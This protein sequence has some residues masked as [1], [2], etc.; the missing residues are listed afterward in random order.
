V[1]GINLFG[2]ISI[3][4]LLYCAPLAVIFESAQWPAALQVRAAQ[5]VPAPRRAA[6]VRA[7]VQGEEGQ[8]PVG[9]GPACCCL[10]GQR[11]GPLLAHLVPPA[12]KVAGGPAAPQEECPQPGRD[13]PTGSTS[14]T[15]QASPLTLTESPPATTLLL[16]APDLLQ[17][18]TDS[19]GA[20]GFYQLLAVGGLFYHLYN[21]V[22]WAGAGGGGLHW[23]Y[24]LRWPAPTRPSP[25]PSYRRPPT[26]C[27]TRASRP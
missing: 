10:A 20:Q 2:L 3:T 26:W 21:Q 12:D 17:A 18:A 1:D 22:G 24:G 19:M 16:P 6:C 25:H 27:W 11:L 13:W 4:S 15:P 7:C 23:P 9:S 14:S 5:A 8:P